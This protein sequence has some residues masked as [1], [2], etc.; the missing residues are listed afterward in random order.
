MTPVS[1][2]GGR[3]A[4]T[5]VDRQGRSRSG[6]PGLPRD[7]ARLYHDDWAATPQSEP[8]SPGKTPV[9]VR[10]VARSR[11][12]FCLARLPPEPR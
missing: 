1:A 10:M 9:S 8:Q 6:C 4:P 12:E 3:D 7:E 2:G 11:E 5:G